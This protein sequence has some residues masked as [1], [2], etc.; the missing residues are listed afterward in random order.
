MSSLPARAGVPDAVLFDLGGVLLGWDPALAFA[1]E[2]DPALVP[3]YL[4]TIGFGTWNRE[5]DAGR[6]FAE[7]EADLRERLPEH[8][9]AVPAYRRHFAR[10]LTGMVPGTGAVLAELGQRG[11]RLA[12]LTNWSAETFPLAR[13][14]FGLLSRFEGVLVSGEERLAKPDPRIFTLALSRFGLVAQRTVF[15]DD[16]PANVEAAA[17]L[18]LVALPFT[19]AERLRADLVGLGL[20]GPRPV[21][22]G[23]LHHL[24]ER[25]RWEQAQAA[26]SYPW[27]TRGRGYEAEGFVH[28][29]SPAQLDGSR[30][31][32][33]GD[34]ADADLVVLELDPARLSAPVVVEDLGA[35]PFPHLYG[36][37]RPD[38]VV[39][40]HAYP[41]A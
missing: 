25:D 41:L 30:R 14:R 9:G 22:E 1:D 12:A 23:P 33:F 35:G 39:R 29:S 16:S 4:E 11:T 18:G 13:E 37:L 3:A 34:L 15:V 28:L 20:L 5:V 31:R 24:T 2:M 32:F 38:E 21:V 17:S 19:G 10:T 40:V 26:G 6:T 8:A 36:P 7:V 27:S